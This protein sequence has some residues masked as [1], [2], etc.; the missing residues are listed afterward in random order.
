TEK[1]AQAAQQTAQQATEKTAQAA[2]QTAQAAQAAG[3]PQ[4]PSSRVVNINNQSELAAHIMRSRGVSE[5]VVNAVQDIGRSVIEARSS[6]DSNTILS[7]IN[8]LERVREVLNSTKLEADLEKDWG[9]L[10]AFASSL[11]FQSGQMQAINPNERV[12]F[13]KQLID[14]EIRKMTSRVNTIAAQAVTR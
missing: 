5:Q 8:K 10:K 2:Q 6:N 4:Q 1:T 11:G 12:D 3:A 14:S 9:F 7:A 13:L